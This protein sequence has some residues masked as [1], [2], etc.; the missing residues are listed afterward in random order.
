MR[1]PSGVCPYPGAGIDF[2][3]PWQDWSNGK[4]ANGA[5]CQT[6]CDQ[7]NF[8]FKCKDGEWIYI[9]QD[10]HSYPACLYSRRCKFLNDKSNTTELHAVL[11]TRIGV[12]SVPFFGS[13]FK[14][15][16]RERG[17]MGTGDYYEKVCR[18]DG[19]WSG[20]QVDCLQDVPFQNKEYKLIKVLPKLHV[21]A[22]GA[23]IG[24]LVTVLV[25]VDVLWRKVSALKSEATTSQQSHPVANI[26]TAEPADLD[27][28]GMLRTSSSGYLIPDG[29][30]YAARRTFSNHSY[31]L[32]MEDK[33]PIKYSESAGQVYF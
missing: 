12:W 27:G 20:E 8:K 24:S 18:A 26:P 10:A 17:K 9:D 13:M 25:A 16:C 28:C 6:I 15:R 19:S 30:H 3:C 22:L 14:V 1:D 32:V 4:W 2:S 11:E 23:F 5:E 31:G 33:R 21:L 7:K 29:Q